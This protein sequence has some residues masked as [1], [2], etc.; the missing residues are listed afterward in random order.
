MK[1]PAYQLYWQEIEEASNEEVVQ[2]LQADTVDVICVICRNRVGWVKVEDLD[3]PLRGSMF[4]KYPGCE[5]WPLPLPD[6]GPKDFICPHASE[7]FFHLF[8]NYREKDEENINKLLQPNGKFYEVNGCPCGC[9]GVVRK[10]R[11]FAAVECYH[12][13]YGSR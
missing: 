5:N 2:E 1:V 8:I 6:A 10:K 3:L 7:D 12:R 4:N 11:K 9:G 13:L